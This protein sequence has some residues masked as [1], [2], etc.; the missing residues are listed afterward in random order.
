MIL[1]GNKYLVL[2]T[3]E[4]DLVLYDLNEATVSQTID[5][6]HK[7]EIWELAMHSSP[8]IK[9]AKGQLLIA[10]AS[11]DHSIKFWNIV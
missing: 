10:S 4:G 8:Q 6:A 3:K 5:S 11:A 9:E 2:G 7:K 1:P